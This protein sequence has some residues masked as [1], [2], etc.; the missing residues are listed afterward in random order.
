MS[1]YF[2]SPIP[3]Y[4]MAF[5]VIVAL[6]IDGLQ[7]LCTVTVVGI[8]ATYGLDVLALVVFFIWFKLYGIS[9]T[10]PKQLL[11]VLG[12]SVVELVPV[13]SVFPAWT[14]MVALLITFSTPLGK[15]AS[16]AMTGDVFKASSALKEIRQ[17]RITR[18]EQQ[19]EGSVSPKSFNRQ[20]SIGYLHSGYVQ[21]RQTM[22]DKRAA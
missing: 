22:Q 4:M 17:N 7:A 9:F 11:T 15:A 16:A 19:T 18:Q 8:I 14:G 12:G 3:K 21:K 10:S 2:K 1:D 20:N 6:G 13:L 5:M